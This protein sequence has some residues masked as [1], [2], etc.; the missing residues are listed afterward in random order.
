MNKILIGF[1]VILAVILVIMI[2]VIVMQQS[3]A[4]EIASWTATPTRTPN[5]SATQLSLTRIAQYTAQPTWTPTTSPS[6]EP[7]STRRASSTPLKSPT[8]DAALRTTVANS[9]QAALQQ[10][11]DPVSG[12]EFQFIG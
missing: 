5:I 8:I 11:G 10:M 12:M 6:P 9:A 1:I 2:A 4:A 7:T 3:R